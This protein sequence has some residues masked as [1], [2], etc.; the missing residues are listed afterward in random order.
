MPRLNRR[1]LLTGA[2]A[3]AL[4]GRAPAARAEDIPGVTETE[5]KIGSTIALSGPVSALGTIA[6]CQAAYFRMINDAG[7]IAGRKIN[8]IYYDDAFNP[9]K[10]AEATRQL[11]EADNVSFL[12]SQLGTAPNS[13]IVKYANA[14]KVPH[15][16]LS[17]NGDKWGDYKTYPWTMGFAPSARTEAQIFVKHALAEKPDAKFA[18]LYQND[19]LGKDFLAGL[20]DVLQARYDSL[21]QAVS[22][23]VTDPT[24]DSQLI[25]LRASNADVLIS[26]VTAKF[27]AQ[28]I[29][30]IY[31]L[32][33]KPTH[34]ITSGAA[35]VNSSIIPAGADRA[36]GVISST[37]IKDPSDPS[38]AGDADLKTYLAFMAKYYPEGNTKEAY[39]AYAYTVTGVMC[40]VL[41][42]CK[43]DF[44]RE[45]IM[46]E[47]NALK[48]LDLPLLL[49]GVRVNTS[50]TNHHP[51]RQVQLQRWD[52]NAYVRFGEIIE[53]ANI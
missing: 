44:R 16:F 15:L 38:W 10:T 22:Y 51:L 14:K 41:D 12:F 48:N 25:T 35:S 2:A 5:I 4:V 29:R 7:G 47:A 43:G 45:T 23:E 39:N 36:V 42:Q 33:W 3:A 13:A 28:A 31:D 40:H 17:V 18:L 46:R 53:G 8:F 26:G 6:R 32:G 37:Y 24:I 21:V 20:R 52:G 27:S 49:P 1:S 50:E 30:K 11:I 34:Y 9:S 19:D